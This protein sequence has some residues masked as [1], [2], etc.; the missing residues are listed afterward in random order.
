[1]GLDQAVPK[2]IRGLMCFICQADHQPA[3]PT[4][5]FGKEMPS[6]IVVQ[7]YLWHSGFL[8]QSFTVLVV[9]QH[10]C[11]EDCNNTATLTFFIYSRSLAK[12]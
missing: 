3:G 1:M 8:K 5:A 9:Y 6:K 2:K 10:S 4:T 11:G 12:W 7:L